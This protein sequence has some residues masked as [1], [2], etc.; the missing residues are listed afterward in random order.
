MKYLYVPKGYYIFLQG[1]F[2]ENRFYGIIKG[3]VSIRSKKVQLNFTGNKEVEEQLL[4]NGNSRH[5]YKLL[6]DKLFSSVNVNNTSGSKKSLRKTPFGEIFKRSSMDEYSDYNLQSEIMKSILD[7]EEENQQMTDGMCFGEWSLLNGRPRSASVYTLEDTHLFYLEKEE[8]DVSLSKALLKGEYEKKSFLAKR[9]FNIKD[10]LGQNSSYKFYAIYLDCNDILFTQLDKPKFIY[11]IYEGECRLAK[12]FD[13]KENK[14]VLK[15]REDI[16]DQRN[17][18]ITHLKLGKGAVAGL[19]ALS[20]SEFYDYNLICNRDCTILLKINLDDLEIM[21]REN[22]IFLKELHKEQNK[23]IG[24]FKKNYQ[25]IK[26]GSYFESNDKKSIGLDYEKEKENMQKIEEE[27]RIMNKT[28]AKV[29]KNNVK[30]MNYF[31]DKEKIASIGKLNLIK[32]E[33]ELVNTE[34]K[35][36]KNKMSTTF[37]LE[38]LLN[39][40]KIN[41]SPFNRKQTR[42]NT[43]FKCMYLT[44]LRN[45]NI[46]LLNK[47]PFQNI[48]SQ[49]GLALNTEATSKYSLSSKPLLTIA[50][51]VPKKLLKEF[52]PNSQIKESEKFVRKDY[53]T[54]TIFKTLILE[55]TDKKDEKN[56]NNLGISKDIQKTIKMWSKIKNSPT[57]YDS[58][59]FNL[60]LLTLNK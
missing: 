26:N 48:D 32:L 37:F 18:M 5:S 9:L 27:V 13:D 23:H 43:E 51:G 59:Y 34:N 52:S 8:F 47:E 12:A 2:E 10:G 33:K 14:L 53:R 19:E 38:N 28:R 36:K 35:E 25:T 55:N 30:M 46:K 3:R 22:I 57:S 49:V 58:G 6:K 15:T 60:P 41:I 16:I 50:D 45:E 44:N 54:F 20:A 11:F 4:Q 7:S 42:L 21:N 29:S 17:K 24:E 40:E 1:D 56:K 39:K 31:I